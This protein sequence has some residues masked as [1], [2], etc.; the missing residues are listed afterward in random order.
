MFKHRSHQNEERDRV[1][2]FLEFLFKISI[3]KINLS[4]FLINWVTGQEVPFLKDGKQFP[5]TLNFP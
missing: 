2:Q 3:E 5:F 1:P 4:F